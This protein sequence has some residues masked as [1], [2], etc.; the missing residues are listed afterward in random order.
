[1][2][3]Y[4]TDKGCW[5][6]LAFYG[7]PA[8]GS[9]TSLP[10]ASCHFNPVEFDTK[11]VRHLE[12]GV[13]NTWEDHMHKPARCELSLEINRI[14]RLNV[15][16]CERTGSGSQDPMYIKL[17][18]DDGEDCES[19]GLPIGDSQ[20]GHFLTFS[21]GSL[22]SCK[23]FTVTTTTTARL[24]NDGNDDLCI[25]DLYLDTATQDGKTKVLR[26]RYDANT[27]LHYR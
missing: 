24:F 2:E 9:T 15:K 1:M 4:S 26:C 6:E 13:W 12:N 5:D 25:T 20:I 10:F 17:T 7:N 18:N 11:Q 16:V 19:E 3:N 27:H 22:G 21:S 23:N 14:T 8:N